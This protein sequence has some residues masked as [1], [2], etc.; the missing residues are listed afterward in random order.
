MK[1]ASLILNVVLLVAVVVL[2]ILHFTQKP[3]GGGA[4]G[5]NFT[6]SDVKVAYVNYD[7]LLKYYDFVKIGRDKLDAQAKSYDAQLLARQTSL[8]REVQAYQQGANNLTRGQAIALE[9]DLQKKGQNLQLFQQ[10]LSQQLEEER[11]KVVEQLHTK[12]TDYL[13]TYSKERGIAAVLKFDRESD[14]LYAGDSL[15]ISKD[16]IKGLN[17]AW[18]IESAKPAATTK[19]ADTTKTKK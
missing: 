5:M 12:L 6:P 2:F 15:D 4:S 18:K 14:V 17:D 9:E 3:S 1:N 11:S 10:S 13:K 7:T 19:P 16:V 8:Q